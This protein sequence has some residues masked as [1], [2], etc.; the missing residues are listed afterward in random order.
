MYP[1]A[2]LAA[3]SHTALFLSN[4]LYGDIHNMKIVILFILIVLLSLTGCSKMGTDVTTAPSATS[5]P[6]T[7][8]STAPTTAPTTVPTTEPVTEPTE[9]E[10]KW[11]VP[12]GAT[13]LT[14][15][16]LNYFQSFLEQDLTIQGNCRPE[17]NWFNL[18][19][20]WEFETPAQI[21]LGRLFYMGARGDDTPYEEHLSDAEWA[22]LDSISERYRNFDVVYISKDTVESVLETY[23]GITLEETEQIGMDR[24]VYNPDTNRYYSAISDVGFAFDFKVVGGYHDLD[25]N[26]VLIVELWNGELMQMTLRSVDDHYQML[27]N[28]C[29]N[30]EEFP[31]LYPTN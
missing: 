14:D 19:V 25:S 4:T 16:E 31:Q 23:F 9:P 6:T 24:F 7:V 18:V 8:P 10:A 26:T 21:N 13:E 2:A 30:K 3:M 15:E 28:V 5:V 20:E 11:E 17:S 29:I 27:S 22:F 1:F 12:D